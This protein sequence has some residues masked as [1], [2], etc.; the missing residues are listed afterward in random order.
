MN[1]QIKN[2]WSGRV[3]FE[4][5]AES[6]G[7]AILIALKAS[8]NLIGANLRGANLIGANLRG[9]NLSGANLI[10]ANL[11][12]ANLSDADLHGANLSG[13]DLHGA[14]LSGANL[15][16]ANLIGADLH[17]ANLIGANLS[18]ANLSG[19]NLS[20]AD[21]IGADLSGAKG[22]ELPI[23]RTRILADGDIVGW[24]KCREGVLVKLLIPSDAKRSNA[25]GR[26][27]RAEFA[28]VVEIIGADEAVSDYDHA[29]KYKVGEIVNP[30]EPFSED[31]QNE[32]ASGIH[33][34]ITR[35]EAE[36]Y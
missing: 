35:L 2:R 31:W 6:L 36:K 18:D 30:K 22:A 28:K 29:F 4:T 20:G 1:I 32:C 16:G 34:F 25:F 10:G 21:L 8:A 14:N 19:A 33:F 27:C 13:A 3:Q 11:I 7:Q 12:G 5:D 24:K 9:A 15:H 23:A 26:K 17:G